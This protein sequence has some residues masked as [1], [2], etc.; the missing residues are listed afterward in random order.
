MFYLLN[1]SEYPQVRDSSL[2]LSWRGIKELTQ[3]AFDKEKLF[4]R[5]YISSLLSKYRRQMGEGV[6]TRE[7]G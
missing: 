4:I 6:K 2:I 1:Y 5:A 7:R 3:Y